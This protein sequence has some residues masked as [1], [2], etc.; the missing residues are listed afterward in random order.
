MTKK[1]S[2]N[3]FIYYNNNNNE[4]NLFI[5]EI[6]NS[7]I[8]NFILLI[9]NEFY[10]E[11]DILYF[12]NF[13]DKNKIKKINLY[14][15]SKYLNSIS[16]IPNARNEKETK[17]LFACK[18]YNSKKNKNGIL[19]II[20]YL[21]DSLEMVKYF[22]PTDNFEVYCFYPIE[23]KKEE[24]NNNLTKNRHRINT[25]KNTEDNSYSGQIN[26][27][28]IRINRYYNAVECSRFL[29][30]GFD[31]KQKKPLIK[32]YRLS[33]NNITLEPEIEKIKDIEIKNKENC[34]GPI[35]CIMQSENFGEILAINSNGDMQAYQI[36]LMNIKNK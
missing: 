33:F 32:L 17:I 29:A 36:F 13:H 28:R 27:N 8:Q 15:F 6:L 30:G 19:L 14:F 31:N 10:N 18:E 7:K 23:N 34:N 25:Q 24:A 26:N 22:Y 12:I 2:F 1:N 4:T 11:N 9:K 35:I 5:N 21:K 16:E 3:Y 20:P